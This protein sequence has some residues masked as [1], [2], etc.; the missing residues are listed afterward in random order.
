MSHLCD[1]HS[2]TSSSRMLQTTDVSNVMKKNNC[3]SYWGQKLYGVRTRFSYLLSH[4]LCHYTDY[5]CPMKPFFNSISNF[6]AN[7]VSLP[8]LIVSPHFITLCP[9]SMISDFCCF[10]HKKLYF[11][12]L[13][14]MI[15]AKNIWETAIMRPCHY[16]GV[17]Q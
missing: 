16:N 13:T 8:E 14:Q 11:L 17:T 10:F 9:V 5:G 3:A 12:D 2:R 4:K 15:L 1:M 7:W 6:F